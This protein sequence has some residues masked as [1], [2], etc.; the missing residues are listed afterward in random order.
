MARDGTGYNT[1]MF[2]VEN[3]GGSDHLVQTSA[4]VSTSFE[5]GGPVPADGTV[6]RPSS[7]IHDEVVVTDR[8]N[9]N[10]AKITYDVYDRFGNKV[11]EVDTYLSV[12]GSR[13]NSVTR[14]CDTRGPVVCKVNDQVFSVFSGRGPDG[15]DHPSDGDAGT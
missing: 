11:A 15:R 5:E 10:S 1:S 4:T 12:P 6:I 8:W 13:W 14:S 2:Y 7:S 9:G 3:R